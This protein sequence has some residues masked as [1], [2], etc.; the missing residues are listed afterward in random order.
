L[1]AILDIRRHLE[2]DNFSSMKYVG[3]KY[4]PKPKIGRK[5]VQNS[6]SNG[7]KTSFS[8]FENRRHFEKL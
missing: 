3:L 6:L 8:S 4:K 2:F 1:A 7:R 5:N